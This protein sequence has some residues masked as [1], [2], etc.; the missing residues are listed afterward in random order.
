MLSLDLRQYSFL[1]LPLMV[2][3]HYIS[4]VESPSRV[5]YYGYFSTRGETLGIEH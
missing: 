4:H 1:L 2:D 3:S 5:G